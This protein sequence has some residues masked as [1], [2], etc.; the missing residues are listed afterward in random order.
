MSGT[1]SALPDG[2]VLAF[3]GDDFTGSTDA[4]EVMAFAGLDTVLFLDDPTPE[5]LARFPSARAVGIA[6]VSRSRDPAWMA[7]NLP[8]RFA[9]L[10]RLGA[11]LLQYKI[12]S[13]FD[14][15]PHVGSIGRAVD[16]G[17]PF[18]RTPFSPMIVGAPRLRRFQAFGNLFAT[19]DD[20][21]YRLDRHPTMSRHPV[22]PMGE[23]DLRLHV[24]RQTGRRIE[25]IHFV[26]LRQG[27]GPELLGSLAGPD[28][29][30]VLIDVLDE[31]TLAE[32][33]RLVWETR[34]D[35]VFTASSSG[36][37]YAL[38]AHWRS[39]GLLPPEA[40]PPRAPSVERIAV[41]SGSCS[42]GTAAQVDWAAG[43]G[44]DAIRL[45]AA[46]TVRG[47]GEAEAARCAE[48]ALAALG[49][50]RDPLVYSASG[51]QDPA[52]AGVAD[53][54]ARAGLTPALANAR[55][56]AA[57][58]STL[59]RVLA[60]ASLRRVAVAGGDTSGEVMSRL[61]VMALTALA[62]LAPGSPLCTA[63]PHDPER[64]SV[65]VALKGGQIG[66]PD[67]FGAVRRGAPFA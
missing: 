28:T 30:L 9:S 6:G 4:M 35:G 39:E 27:R 63:W 12:C 54:A 26:Q 33:G 43:H 50:G 60:R 3:Y 14:S 66:G 10:A 36:L 37:Q 34:G 58:A 42:P 52:L 65:E 8:A 13:T 49:A 38:V 59:Q 40:P 17:V 61:R 45:D 51:P 46:R 55:I 1:P 22:T 23:A 24:S 7:E 41:V 19:L 62:P 11:P 18:G 44:F 53:A 21:G 29:P 5:R 64:A 20:V 16:L 67:F 31:E 56:G 25:L 47:E 2:L 48:A 15:A 57:L 32:A